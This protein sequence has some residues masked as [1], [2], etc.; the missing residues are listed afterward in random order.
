[1]LKL[2]FTPMFKIVF[3][4]V[5]THV[6]TQVYTHEY[7]HVK[8]HVQT[9]F[10]LVFTHLILKAWPVCMYIYV[11]MRVLSNQTGLFVPHVSWKN[12]QTFWQE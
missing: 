1:M 2:I 12:K 11:R 6:F 9:Y 7:T 8:I 10:T 5:Y 4:P 3:S